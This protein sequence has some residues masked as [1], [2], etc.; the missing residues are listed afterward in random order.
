M[1]ILKL[2]LLL[3]LVLLLKYPVNVMKFQILKNVPTK[4]W[5]KVP[6][7]ISPNHIHALNHSLSLFQMVLGATNHHNFYNQM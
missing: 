3:L 6:L 7:S 2:N 5:V 4:I 1:V